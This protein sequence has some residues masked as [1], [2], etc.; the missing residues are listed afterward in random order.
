MSTSQLC[1]LGSCSPLPLDADGS[2]GGSPPTPPRELDA[3]VPPPSSSVWL[4]T[5]ILSPH[6]SGSCLV[7]ARFI[8]SMSCATLESAPSQSFHDN[9]QCDLQG[10]LLQFGWHGNLLGGKT[11]PVEYLPGEAHILLGLIGSSMSGGCAPLSPR[12]SGK[13]TRMLTSP[14]RSRDHGG[15]FDVLRELSFTSPFNTELS[16][17]PASDHSQMVFRQVPGRQVTCTPGR[18]SRTQR[19][20]LNLFLSC[21][22]RSVIHTSSISG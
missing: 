14:A 5:W 10:T 16:H 11:E 4:L 12:A 17:R 9:V 22:A 20:N 1:S 15:S 2:G 8:L 19:Q 21:A 7:P 3:P 13:S 6:P 18:R